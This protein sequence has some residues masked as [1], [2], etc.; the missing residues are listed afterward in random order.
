MCF[1]ATSSPLTPSRLADNSSVRPPWLFYFLEAGNN[2]T[3]CVSAA[4]RAALGL[5]NVRTCAVL[6]GHEDANHYSSKNRN[7]QVLVKIR[8]ASKS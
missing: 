6:P 4:G 3:V 1:N 7:C 5:E 2:S 8:E